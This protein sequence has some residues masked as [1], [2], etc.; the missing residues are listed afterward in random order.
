MSLARAVWQFGEPVH[1]V[2]YYA[3]ERRAATD[4]LGLKGGWMSYFGCRAAPLGAVGAPVVTALF[5]NFAPAMVAR[6]I[7]DAWRY[8]SPA[9]LV[10]ARADAMD[11]ALRRVLG[12]ET[13]RSPDIARAA[14]LAW[15]AVAGCDMAGRAVGAA[16]QAVPAPADAHLRLWQALTAIREHR[17]DGHVHCLVDAGVSPSHALVLQAGTGRSP[18]EGLRANRGWTDDD[19]TAASNA[20]AERGLVDGDGRVTAAGIELRQRIEDETDRLAAPIVDAIGDAAAEELVALLRPLATAV[21]DVGAVPP[22]NNMGVPWPPAELGRP[23]R[24]WPPSAASGRAT[25]KP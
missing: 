10:D 24:S 21:M 20:L 9:A 25:R 17:G 1:A 18:E 19:W 23:T 14:E 11:R 8:A 2:I 15:A 16:N 4:Q 3:P 22:L 7:P 6:A 12:D 5:Y 13:V